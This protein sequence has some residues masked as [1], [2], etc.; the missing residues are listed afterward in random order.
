M[1]RQKK[2]LWSNF[3]FSGHMARHSRIHAGLKPYTC[4]VERCGS[5][6]S[7]QDNML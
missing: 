2:V 7:R 4:P 1:W 3:F 6:F 5:K